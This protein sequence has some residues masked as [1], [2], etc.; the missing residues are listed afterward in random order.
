M[1]FRLRA[2]RSSR[3]D[4]HR[5]SRLIEPLE[6]RV[7]LAAYSLQTL[8]LF[9][10]STGQNP[11]GGL[12]MDNQGNLFGATAT[13]GSGGANADGTIFELTAGSNTPTTLASFTG[14]NGSAPVGD[15]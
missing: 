5:A 1:R 6:P 8:A 14:G 9:S 13:G 12:V 15:L 2:P 7:L 4:P 3:A 10:H 11:T